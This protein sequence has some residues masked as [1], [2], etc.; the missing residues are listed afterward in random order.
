MTME[1]KNKMKVKWQSFS[2]II[3]NVQLTESEISFKPRFHTV[4]NS[5]HVKVY[6]I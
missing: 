2:Q 4:T 6:T 1:S 5:I 3:Y